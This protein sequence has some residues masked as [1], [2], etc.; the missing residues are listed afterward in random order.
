MS[1]RLPG[2]APTC[3]LIY[4]FNI[5]YRCYPARRTPNDPRVSHTSLRPVSVHRLLRGWRPQ[6][7]LC[8][9]GR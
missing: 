8:V 5:H 3:L 4:L 7:G 9:A 1:Q 6:D 2:R